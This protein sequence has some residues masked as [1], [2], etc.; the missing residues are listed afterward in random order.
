MIDRKE[1]E[2]LIAYLEGCAL[3][4]GGGGLPGDLVEQLLG[5][6]RTQSEVR[7]SGAPPG[8]EIYAFRVDVWL[9][10]GECEAHFGGSNDERAA[11]AMFLEAVKCSPDRKVTLSAGRYVLKKST[12]L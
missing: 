11:R 5:A 10:N 8:N 6:L 12:R 3:K 7:T 2:E 9:Q 1:R 4:G